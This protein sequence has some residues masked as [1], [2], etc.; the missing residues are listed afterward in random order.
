MDRIYDLIILGGGP[1]G[2]SAAL[3]GARSGMDVLR[4][5]KLSAGEIGRAHV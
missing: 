4:L 5:E 2:Y 3:Y 1:G